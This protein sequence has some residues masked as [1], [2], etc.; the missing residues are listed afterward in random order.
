MLRIY[1]V[2]Y[3]NTLPFIKG[4]KFLSQQ[5]AVEI[6][7]STPS[8]CAEALRDHKADIALIPVGSLSDFEKIHLISDFCI[9]CDGAVKSVCLF[10]NKHWGQI[11]TIQLDPASRTSNLLL[12]LLVKEYWKRDDISYWE[13]NNVDE[14]PD[15]KLII[16]DDS[17]QA[18]D[19]YLYSYDL[20]Y[21][22]KKY[23]GLPFVFAVWASRTENH[24]KLNEA[25]NEAFAKGISDTITNVPKYKDL[26][27]EEVRTYFDTNISYPFDN[28]KR[29]ALNLFL[30]KT[31]IKTDWLT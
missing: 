26:N 17:F 31:G 12:Q 3:L 5:D 25:F 21:F 13:I 22:W 30:N 4:L 23:T 10:T 16:G 18:H 27:E 28:L 8:K 15:A 6:I 14:E 24:K 2:E 9:G 11:K 7:Q 29:T 20:G 1:A 19:T